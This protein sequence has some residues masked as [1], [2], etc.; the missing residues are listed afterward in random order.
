MIILDVLDSEDKEELKKIVSNIKVNQL[1]KSKI[2]G[3]YHSEKVLL[4]SY[5]LAKNFELSNADLRILYDASIYHDIGRKT[6][7]EDPF[8]GKSSA[9][10]ISSVVN[11]TDELELLLLQSIIDGHSRK[12]S[13]KNKNF[14]DYFWDIECKNEYKNR[15]DSLYDILK[16]ADAL[17]RIRIK[18]NNNTLEPEYLRIP[19]SIELI[20]VSEN[21]NDKYIEEFEKNP[22]LEGLKTGN[23]ECFHSFGNDIFKLNSIITNGILSYR[24]MK[25]LNIKGA[26]NFNGGNNGN[27]ISCVAA[28]LVKDSEPL[29]T[30]A[31]KNFTEKG[32]SIKTKNIEWF[33]AKEKESLTYTVCNGRPYKKAN[34]TDERYVQ[35]KIE[36]DKIEE[37]FISNKIKDNLVID[38][39]FILPSLNYDIIEGRV[40]YFLKNT[41]TNFDDE[42]LNVLAKYKLIIQKKSEYKD[43]EQRIININKELQ[44]HIGIR[45]AAYY[46]SLT[47]IDIYSLTLENIVDYELEQLNFL[48]QEETTKIS[49]KKQLALSLDKC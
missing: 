23:S 19:R 46:S 8:H 11:Y 36:P 30:S 6:D 22:N 34:Y 41:K 14:E 28:D 26:R 42:L 37:I 24:E 25:K 4:F 16:D 33:E 32:I 2:H 31:F 35:D 20:E 49:Y 43:I 10:K 27:F 9:I 12:D 47:N 48:K 7:G 44:K 39:L 45:V 18:E 29:N 13:D 40:L 38:S 3:I 5:L 21:I 17:D 15:Y 1:Y